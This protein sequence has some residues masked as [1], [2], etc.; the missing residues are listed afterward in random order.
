[1]GT[2]T[3]Q[4]GTRE[5]ARQ[6]QSSNDRSAD[7]G[8]PDGVPVTNGLSDGLNRVLVLFV[9]GKEYLKAGVVDLRE[10]SGAYGFFFALYFSNPYFLGT[11]CPLPMQ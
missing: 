2:F 10:R 8:T 1:V 4:F 7:A 11:S 9:G 3:A 5:V 6:A